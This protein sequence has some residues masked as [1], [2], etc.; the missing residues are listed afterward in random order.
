[1][2]LAMPSPLAL[3]STSTVRCSL[4]RVATQMSNTQGPEGLP[5][6][7]APGRV[8]C[9]YRLVPSKER[10]GRASISVV[11]TVGPRFTGVDQGSDVLAR[12]ATHR[13]SA[14]SVPVRSEANR[15][16]RPSCRIAGCRSSDEEFSSVTGA[17]GPYDPSGRRVL[18]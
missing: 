11:L 14:P 18:T 16:S 8:D 13:S 9:K 12:V 17:P 1:M 15:I 4:V 7:T 3:G 10:A 2:V 6:P 5:Q